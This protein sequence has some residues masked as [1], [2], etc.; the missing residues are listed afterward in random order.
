LF[1]HRLFEPDIE[2]DPEKKDTWLEAPDPPI[3]AVPCVSVSA[4]QYQTDAVEFHLRI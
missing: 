4:A 3:V 2:V 1:H